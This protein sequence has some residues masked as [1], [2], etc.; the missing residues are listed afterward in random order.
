MN[1]ENDQVT[2]ILSSESFKTLVRVRNTVRF[3]LSFLVLACHAFFVGGIAFYNQWFGS[4]WSVGSS[5][6]QGIIVT[7]AIIVIM[8]VL[9]YIYIKISD[10]VIDP[11]QHRAVTEAADHG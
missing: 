4:P 3:I 9:E 11:L 8:I 6:P 2:A 1:N 7:V 10:R 5:I